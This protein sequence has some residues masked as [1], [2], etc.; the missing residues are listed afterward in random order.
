MA[1][2][3]QREERQWEIVPEGTHRVRVQEVRKRVSQTGRDMLEITFEVSGMKP[4]LRY[5]LVFLED[6]PEISNRNLTNFFDSFGGIEMGDLDTNHWIGKTGACVVQHEDY[7]GNPTA[8]SRYFVTAD[9][10]N[11]LPPWQNPDGSKPVGNGFMTIPDGI[12]EEVP[13]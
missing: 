11:D 13:F 6:R 4:T 3:F 9:K 7:N 2:S 1:W 12:E 10:Q 8:R 5:Y